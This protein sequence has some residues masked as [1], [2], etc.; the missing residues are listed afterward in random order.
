M[1]ETKHYYEVLPDTVLFWC[2]V[3]QRRATHKLY[4]DGWELVVCDPKLGGIMVQCRCVDLTGKVQ[5][6]PYV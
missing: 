3:H 2:N 5:I 1:K 4:G 6:D